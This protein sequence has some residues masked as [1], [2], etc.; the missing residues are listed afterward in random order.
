MFTAIE[1]E[2]PAADSGI[3]KGAVMGFRC[4]PMGVRPEMTARNA[5]ALQW[6]SACDLQL[7]NESNLG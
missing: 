5:H 3:H 7:S 1:P 6:N 2:I 4:M